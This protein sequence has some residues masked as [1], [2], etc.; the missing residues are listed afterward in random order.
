MAGSSKSVS[1]GR[2]WLRRLAGVVVVTAMAAGMTA[3]FAS[4][5][6]AGLVGLT[7]IEEQEEST[8]DSNTVT[9]RCP[10]A[11]VLVGTGVSV[12]GGDVLIKDITPSETEV[13]V[14]AVVD[15]DG[16]AGTWTLEAIAMCA[17][18]PVGYEIVSD[19]SL[20]SS[21]P[22]QGA[23]AACTGNKDVIGTA[24]EIDGI[25]T[26]DVMIDTVLPTEGNVHVAAA[27]DQ[28][29]TTSNWSVTAWAI[30][31]DPSTGADIEASSNTTQTTRDNKARSEYCDS[32][33]ITGFGGLLLGAPGQVSITALS[34][35]VYFDTH[36][37]Y[38]RG[39][40]D[41]DGTT[42]NWTLTTYAICV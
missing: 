19:T 33:E 26:G 22:R 37:A 32:G 38:A 39:T 28:N 42:A 23:N 12:S 15:A 36:G 8:D 27:E 6:S 5:A 7:I 20:R 10:N 16:T 2:R 4:P 24:A 31:A 40:E 30:C 29:G 18:E 14:E 9:A 1:F 3:V 35:I 34:P 41:H 17:V 25:V 11:S 21:D 13:E